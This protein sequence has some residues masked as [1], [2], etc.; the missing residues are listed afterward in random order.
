ML[1]AVLLTASYDL[2]HGTLHEGI[3]KFFGIGIGAVV[4][5]EVGRLAL[6]RWLANRNAS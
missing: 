5:R 2:K 4:V 1:T 3:A 6:A